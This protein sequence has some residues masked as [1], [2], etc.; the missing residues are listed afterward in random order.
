M[1][2]AFSLPLAD[3][4]ATIIDSRTLA[5]F[6]FGSLKLLNLIVLSLRTYPALNLPLR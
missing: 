1:K 2:F 6:F 3:L 5:I 4:F